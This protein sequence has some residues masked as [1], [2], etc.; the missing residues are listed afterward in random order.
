MLQGLT[1]DQKFSWRIHVP[2]FEM[3][4]IGGCEAFTTVS[5]GSV[6]MGSGFS[7]SIAAN[8]CPQLPYL[9]GVYA[10]AMF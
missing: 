1:V 4:T 10:N 5:C 9:S 7:G 3:H 2:G 6:Y 8:Y